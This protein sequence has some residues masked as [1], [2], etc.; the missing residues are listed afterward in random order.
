MMCLIRCLFFLEA[1]FSFDLIASHLPGRENMLADDLSLVTAFLISSPRPSCQTQPQPL[2]H[3]S[4]RIYCWNMKVGH[5]RAG[6]GTSPLLQPRISELHK[7]DVSSWFESSFCYAFGVL[8]PF[9]VSETMLCYF[10]TSLAQ[11]G[12]APATIMRR[13]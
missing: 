11:E 9:P 13:Y 8:A 12:I 10:V 5:L 1:R 3:P 4:C 2:Y 7:E 6:Q